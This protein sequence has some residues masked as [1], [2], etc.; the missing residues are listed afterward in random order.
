M[1]GIGW[2]PNEGKGDRPRIHGLMSGVSNSEGGWLIEK[3]VG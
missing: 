3:L 2:L 1:G